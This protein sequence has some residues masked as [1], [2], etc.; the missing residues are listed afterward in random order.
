[1]NLVINDAISFA[2]ESHK[3]QERKFDGSAYIR[4]PLSV[5]GMM[6]EFT[7][8]PLILA[9]C[10]LHD[11]VEDCEDVTL[12]VIHE[13]FGEVVAGYV[14]YATEKSKKTDGTRKV[15]KEI[16]KFHYSCGT[17]VSQDIKVLDMIDNIPSMFQVDSKFAIKYAE[18]KIALLNALNRCSP[19]L[20]T[21]TFNMIEKLLNMDL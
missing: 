21:R 15:R 11:T 6:T 19:I 4:H 10:V 3:D 2:I 8:D 12:E 16:D 18:E 1:M 9:A 7:S 17:S 13:R 14:F 5:M 20:K